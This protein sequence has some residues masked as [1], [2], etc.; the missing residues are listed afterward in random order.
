MKAVKRTVILA[1]IEWHTRMSFWS[2]AL[3]IWDKVLIKIDVYKIVKVRIPFRWS[4]NKAGR[5]TQ[6]I[7]GTK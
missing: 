4:K 5:Q 1:K 2:T 7:K 3:I 6:E